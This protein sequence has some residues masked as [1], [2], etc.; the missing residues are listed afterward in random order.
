MTLPIAREKFKLLKYAYCHMPSLQCKALV[1][2]TLK[3]QEID[4][5]YGL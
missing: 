4:H 1:G 3:P 5:A 2:N